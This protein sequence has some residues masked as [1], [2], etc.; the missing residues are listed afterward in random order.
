MPEAADR[1]ERCHLVKVIRR[2]AL[3]IPIKDITPKQQ[4]AIKDKLTFHFFGKEKLCEECDFFAERVSDVCERCANYK[5]SYKLAR[6]I[7]INERRFMK[8]P[9]GSGFQVLR[10]LN[11]SI[12]KLI[13]KSPD[14]PL[15][16][17]IKFTGEFR[18]GQRE[19]IDAMHRMRRGVLE[20]PPRS[21]KTVMGTAFVCELGQKTLILA[22]QRDWLMGFKETFIGSKTQAALTNLDPTRIKLCK[23]LQDF[24]DHDICLA[25]IQT[26]YSEGGE[27]IL[28][29]IRSMFGAILIDEVH[30]SAADKYAGILAKLNSACAIGFSG[31]PDR[32]D[33]KYTLVDNILGK[34]FHEMKVERERPTIK[35][36][37]TRYS[38]VYKGQVLWTR[39]VSA[40]ENDKKRIDDIAKQA[41]RD[42]AEGHMILIPMAQV[43]PVKT[44]IRRINELAG[45][46][47]AYE[48]SGGLK[49]ADRDRYIEAARNYKIKV[50]VGT[51]K[52]LSVGINIPRA[53]ML[54]ECVLSSNMPNAQQR[55]ARVLTPMK[56]KPKPCIRYFLDDVGV[57]KSCMRAEWFQAMA[58]VFNP[59]ISDQTKRM[60]M[61]YFSSSSSNVQKFDL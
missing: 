6:S 2:E 26:F 1:K 34:V 39:M 20:A 55:F 40:L 28:A 51:Q 4:E 60:L 7:K 56:N 8:I 33:G 16:R 50:L 25:T 54:Y 21:G 37:K 46:K 22:S 12:T 23:T 52:V 58:P 61:Q 43:K 45:K 31:T 13:D 27:K 14:R 11:L 32:K 57:R 24:K 48:F 5:G 44:L 9:V 17:K 42:V 29:K 53:S 3:Y 49:K 30:T 59:I 10:D 36:T 47:L 38:K 19:C 15:K 41:L 18:E 35:L